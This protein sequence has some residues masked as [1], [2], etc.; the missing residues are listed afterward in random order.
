M[1]AGVDREA[2]SSSSTVEITTVN[3]ASRVADLGVA[4]ADEPCNDGPVDILLSCGTNMSLERSTMVNSPRI[5]A[6]DCN[7]R[8]VSTFPVSDGLNCHCVRIG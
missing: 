8:N 4:A 6:G 3:P 7:S 1:I 5:F 2:F